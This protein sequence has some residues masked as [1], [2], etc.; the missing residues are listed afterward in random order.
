MLVNN[1]LTGYTNID[2]LEPQNASD[3]VVAAAAAA[4]AVA[5]VAAASGLLGKP[6]SGISASS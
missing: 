1:P 2:V 3:K 6:L 5:A 4:V